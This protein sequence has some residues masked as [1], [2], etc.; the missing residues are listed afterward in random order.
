MSLLGE[1]RFVSAGHGLQ[2]GIP[3][4]GRGGA[5]RLPAWLAMGWTLLALAACTHVSRPAATA[6]QSEGR[7]SWHARD[8]DD[9]DT[10]H[11]SLALGE[12]AI[13]PTVLAHPAPH[14]PPALVPLQLPP[15]DIPAQLAVN[16]EGRVYNV[17]VQGEATAGPARKAFIAAVRA[18]VAQW[19]FSPLI[20]QHQ[21]ADADGN[22][23][24][25]DLSRPAFSE[26]YV[27]HFELDH[28]V[29]VSDSGRS[30]PAAG[31]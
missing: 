28:G 1:N 3:A 4:A 26:F 8:A 29:P 12:S 25:V 16:G 30:D 19:R 15:Q 5:S 23:H 18:A 2:S 11:Y 13:Q 27:F 24:V 6:T 9:A 10:A 20:I 31:H 14:Y 22:S 17:I 7:T 21:A